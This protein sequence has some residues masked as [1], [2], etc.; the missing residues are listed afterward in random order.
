MDSEGGGERMREEDG[1]EGSVG[2]GDE[3]GGSG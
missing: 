3:G 2:P 1:D